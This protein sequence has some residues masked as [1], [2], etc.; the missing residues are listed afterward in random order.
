MSKTADPRVVADGF[1]ELV[2]MSFRLTSW[3][4]DLRFSSIIRNTGFDPVLAYVAFRRGQEVDWSFVDLEDQFFSCCHMREV[5]G[6]A[7]KRVHERKL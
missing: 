2:P 4:S 6:L 5:S 3:I 7:D 1:G